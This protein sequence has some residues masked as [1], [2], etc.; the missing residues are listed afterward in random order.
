MENLTTRE[1]ASRRLAS[2]KLERS[3]WMS[4]WKEIGEVL[5]PR[6]GRFFATDENRGSRKN[7]ILDDT[8]TGALGTLGAGMQY[9]QTSPAR[10]WVRIETSDPDL[11][12]HADVSLWCDQVTRLIL[13]VFA[14]SNTYNTLHSM[15]EELGAYGVAASIVLPDYENIIHHTPLTIGEYTLGTNSKNQVDSLGRELQ[16]TVAQ[17]VEKY[18]AGGTAL[19]ERSGSWDW[20]RVSSQIKNAWDRHEVDSWIRVQQLI[21]PRKFRDPEKRDNKNMAWR[22][23]VIEEGAN[24][25]LV[26]HEGGFRRFPVIA[27]RWHVSGNDVYGSTWP[28]ARALG[29]IKQLQFE[30]MRKAQ[31]I[32]FQTNPPLMVPSHLKNQESDFLPGG[33]T[34]FDPGGAGLGKV[35]S[36]FKVDLN[37]QHL[38]L[39]I[40]DVRQMVNAAFYAD[41]FLMMDR[42]QGIQ[43]RNQREVEERHEEKLLML[44]PVVERQQNECLGPLI[45]IAFDALSEAG[46]LPPVPESIEGM[47]L[48]FKYTS[49]LAQAQRRASMAGVDR[50]VGAVASIAAAKQDPSV[51]DKVDTDVII[52]KAAGYEGVDAEIIRGKEDT[53]RIREA[54]AQA[55]QAQQQMAEAQQ[56]AETAKT[57]A[58]APMTTDNA[59]TNVVKGFA[60]Q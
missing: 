47:D 3:S 46:A 20:S 18:V 35:E 37:L 28:G 9:G 44:G 48:E 27:P 60:N 41:V 49:V 10:P 2:L 21:E 50:I 40:N 51:W 56:A 59:L 54:R 19:K 52:D 45:D 14:R 42:L 55:Q 15:Y 11:M 16:M 38:L 33:V 22:N 53:Q 24:A 32:D 12:E 25:D 4:H 30:H 7:D 39:D 5:L 8:A 57:L 17:I 36:A 13:M 29:G 1:A 26:M 23:V 31:A 43:P 34:Y 58:A 6:T